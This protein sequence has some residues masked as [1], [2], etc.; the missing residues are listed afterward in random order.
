MLLPELRQF[1]F[2][3]GADLVFAN[4]NFAAGRLF[5]P[6]QLVQQGRLTAAGL[7]D[8]AAKFAFFD[9]KVYVIQRYNAFF[10]NSVDLR[11]FSVRMMGAKDSPPFRKMCLFYHKT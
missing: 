1:G 11:S 10:S 2:V 3:H 9:R 4:E 6:G 8:D 7:A 5:Q